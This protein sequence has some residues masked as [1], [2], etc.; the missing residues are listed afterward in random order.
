M[1]LYL[2]VLIILL[3]SGSLMLAVANGE[4]RT[5]IGHRTPA[6][7]RTP[8]TWRYANR[9]AGWVTITAS[10]AAIGIGFL[11]RDSIEAR[12][13]LAALI[14]VAAVVVVNLIVT[15]TALQKQFDAEGNRRNRPNLGP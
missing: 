7:T 8:L 12:R 2:V 13:S 6:S 14:A 5:F 10:V 3:I 4:P 15:E 9:I 11:L 1:T